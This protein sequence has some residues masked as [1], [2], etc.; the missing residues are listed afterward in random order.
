ML[1]KMVETS[2]LLVNESFE[3]ITPMQTANQIEADQV[4]E[5]E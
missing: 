5:L 1:K 3:Y 2:E 4:P